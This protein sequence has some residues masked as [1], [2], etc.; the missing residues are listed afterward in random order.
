[1]K[2]RIQTLL[3]ILLVISVSGC[4]QKEET[5]NETDINKIEVNE[6]RAIAELAT[7]ECYFHNV[8]KFDQDTNKSWFEFWKKENTK[9]WIEYDGTVTVGIKA[10]DELKI[11]ID[12]ETVNITLPHAEVLDAYVNPESLTEQSFFYDVNS[13]KPTAEM[14]TKAFE[15]AQQDMVEAANAN[16]T[17]LLNAE[18]NAKEL[19]KNYVKNIGDLVGVEYKINWIEVEAA[20]SDNQTE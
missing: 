11:E 15:A 6:M 4:T 1:M 18:D 5:V 13:Q 7:V 16:R 2:K 17:L 12:G 19:L 20:S 10:L 14:E 9:F 3:A 8:A